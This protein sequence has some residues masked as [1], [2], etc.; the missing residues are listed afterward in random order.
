[1]EQADRWQQPYREAVEELDRRERQW[2][3][4]DELLR[5]IAGRLCIAA[6]GLDAGLDGSLNEV[7]S[8]LRRPAEAEP[9]EA[10]LS[11]LTQSVAALDR[12]TALVAPPAANDGLRLRQSL[13][14]ILEHLAEL[15]DAQPRAAALSGRL[16]A[17]SADVLAEIAV[18][19]ADLAQAQIATLQ[20]ARQEADRLLLQF[21]ERLEDI[22]RHLRNESEEHSNA[23]IEQ[24]A[25]GQQL[26]GHT[27]ALVDQTRSA[28]DLG[29]LQE[30]VY[31]HLT[32]IDQR[33]RE[34]RSREET[35]AV[36]YKE[37]TEALYERIESLENQT[38]SLT[39]SVNKLERQASTDGLTRVPNRA[40]YDKRIAAELQQYKRDQRPRCIAAIDIDH[41]K[42][43]NDRYGH[44]AG[45]KVLQMLAQHWSRRLRDCDF[46]GRYGG[47]EFVMLLDN[48]NEQQALLLA[49]KLRQSVEKLGFHFRQQPVSVTI[50]CGITGFREGDTP[51]ALFERADRALYEAKRNGRN[52]CCV[53]V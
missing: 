34:H 41:F 20:R 2:R 17:E 51:Q 3:L 27:Q 14:R 47:E 35:R 23:Q 8:T 7:I 9:L 39:R 16:D 48:S 36:A 28:S 37:R 12:D 45:D 44:Q 29:Q 31:R 33:V 49:N 53:E 43:I 15:P 13:K 38:R 50:S 4:T 46:F 26:L 18:G 52:R 5:R 30:Q 22:A 21:S 19:T 10:L 24:R 32:A 11:G 1:M 6:R 42:T 25:F 40:A